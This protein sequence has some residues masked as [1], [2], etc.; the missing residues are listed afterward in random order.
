MIEGL[1]CN[2]SEGTL[3][4]LLSLGCVLNLRAMVH[5]RDIS[6]AVF[7]GTDGSPIMNTLKRHEPK[8]V[9]LGP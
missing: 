6:E 3:A 5:Q 7:A 4:Y 2:L 8:L 9:F 1:C